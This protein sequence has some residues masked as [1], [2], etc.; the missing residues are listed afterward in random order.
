M[1][2]SPI[3]LVQH[4]FRLYEAGDFEALFALADENVE[5]VP[6][7]EPQRL[8]GLG[9]AREFFLAA[10]DPRRRWSAHGLEFEGVDDETVLVTGRLHAAAALGGQPLDLPIA[11]LFTV[12]G[13][14]IARL[15]G[16]LS[17]RDAVAAM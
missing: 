13:G 6:A 2:R 9:P 5:F 4:A 7:S 17:R 16:F 12:C 3:A 11:W 8:Y 1:E 10:G 15:R 14:R